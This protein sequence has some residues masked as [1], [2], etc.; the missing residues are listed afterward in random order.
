MVELHREGSATAACA[1]GLFHT[2]SMIYGSFLL[3]GRVFGFCLLSKRHLVMPNATNFFSNGGFYFSTTY[4]KGSLDADKT[5][6][7]KLFFRDVLCTGECITCR[8]NIITA[9]S[10]LFRKFCVK[11]YKI[12]TS[13]FFLFWLLSLTNSKF[14]CI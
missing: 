14:V 10:R 8:K 3:L 9:I 2:N 6:F 7:F 4:I 11:M 5:N 12:K 13:N 1:A